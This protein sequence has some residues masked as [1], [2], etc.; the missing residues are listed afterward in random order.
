M[1]EQ[2]QDQPPTGRD[3]RLEIP[4]ALR[5]PVRT[6]RYDALK[7]QADGPVTPKDQGVNMAGVSRAY[8]LA[9][10]FI[11]YIL[12]CGGLGHLA[13]RYVVGSGQLW[14][15]VGAAFGLI[16]AGF[17]AYRVAG[18][19]GGEGGSASRRTGGR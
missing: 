3:P 13:D 4:E 7:G 6:S 10:E 1:S 15:V 19:L 9:I 17:R 11:V 14:T 16:G 5:T 12:V 18:Q 8:G 2:P